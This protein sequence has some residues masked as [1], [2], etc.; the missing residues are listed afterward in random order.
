MNNNLILLLS[1]DQL[2]MKPYQSNKFIIMKWLQRFLIRSRERWRR[3]DL[4]SKQH[5]RRR[6]KWWMKWNNNLNS[7]KMSWLYLIFRCH[8]RLLKMK[9][10]FWNNLKVSTLNVIQTLKSKRMKWKKY[11]ISLTYDSSLN[12]ITIPY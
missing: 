8:S 3:T 6:N 7:T 5:R 1:R 9:R 4:N 12:P 2:V 11:Q 10:V